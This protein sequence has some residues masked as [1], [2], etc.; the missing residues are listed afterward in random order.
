VI[1]EYAYVEW[2]AL[3]RSIPLLHAVKVRNRFVIVNNNI[4]QLIK[5]GYLNPYQFRFRKMGDGSC[6]IFH[7]SIKGFGHLFR[8]KSFRKLYDWDAI[9]AAIPPGHGREIN[10]N[11]KS[12][13]WAIWKYERNG[14][15]RRGA[16]RL[17]QTQKDGRTQQI[18]CHLQRRKSIG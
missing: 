6:L 12:V 10:A 15:I 16:F 13:R 14:V 1:P 18:L 4:T 17:M 3:L 2:L 11:R 8:A 9:F 7:H 5:R